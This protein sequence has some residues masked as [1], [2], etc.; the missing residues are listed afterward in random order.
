MSLLVHYEPWRMTFIIACIKLSFVIGNYWRECP[1]WI[2]IRTILCLIDY[3]ISSLYSS[4]II[5]GAKE[6]K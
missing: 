4:I 5:T 1:V 6:K 3:L 2:W